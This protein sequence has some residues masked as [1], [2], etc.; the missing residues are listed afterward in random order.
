M[1][2]GKRLQDPA[3]RPATRAFEDATGLLES[4]GLL[5]ARAEERGYLFF[6]RFMPRE[7]I[8]RVRRAVLAILGE[9]GF[10]DTK[11]PLMEGSVNQ[12][13]VDRLS[14]KEANWNGVGVPQPVYLAV[15]KLEAFHALAHEPKL[16]RLFD[17]LLGKRAIPHPRNI[18]RLMLP[19]SSLHPTPPHQDFLHIQGDYETWTC[20]IPLG[21]VPRSLGGLS[22]LEGSH[23]AGLLGVSGSPGAGGLETILCG[24][25]YEWAEGDYEA[26]DL[27]VFHSLT[28]HKALRSSTPELMRL[29]CDFRYQA[30]EH[31]IEKASLQ[32]HGP[33]E[34][35]ELYDGWTRPELQ[36]YWR[37]ERLKLV[38][39]DESIRWQKEKIC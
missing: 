9:H 30:A 21:D 28:V 35:A 23:K 13:A 3:A 22:V 37:E 24:M 17:T 2:D 8:L 34:W 29:S 27:I 26:G 36:Y 38:P 20:W 12:E 1:D 16:A 39:F 10:L 18:A 7:D 33:F 32:P 25:D 6:R 31:P 11:R 5:R 15:Q 19:H 4:P 14:E